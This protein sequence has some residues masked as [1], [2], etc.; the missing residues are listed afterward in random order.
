MI[1]P[2][3]RASNSRRNRPRV[4]EGFHNIG[5]SS[6]KMLIHR[7]QGKEPVTSKGGITPP[8]VSQVLES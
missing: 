4:E 7:R 3:A 8:G 2:K 5:D 6:G 1:T